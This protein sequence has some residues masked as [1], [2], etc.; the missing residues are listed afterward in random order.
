MI[1]FKSERYSR[2]QNCN[3]LKKVFDITVCCN[4]SQEHTISL[5][6]SCTKELASLANMC[7]S[8]PKMKMVSID[9]IDSTT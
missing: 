7:T 6:L 9:N 5:C 3:A 8:V 2:C 4:N 1:M